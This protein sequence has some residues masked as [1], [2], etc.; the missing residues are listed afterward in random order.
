MSPSLRY[1]INLRPNDGLSLTY[2]IGRH[3]HS[4]YRSR[5]RCSRTT[6]HSC[7]P[8][9][10]QSQKSRCRTAVSVVC[11]TWLPTVLRMR[12]KNARR[13]TRALRDR[14]TT[15]DQRM[16]RVWSR[17]RDASCATLLLLFLTSPQ[18]YAWLRCRLSHLLV[19]FLKPSSYNRSPCYSMNH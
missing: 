4:L 6:G 11:S 17:Y 15:I 1:I 10:W 9:R 7:R 3:H 8:R 13:E 16:P 14:R 12:T 2:S 18:S 19:C 5:A